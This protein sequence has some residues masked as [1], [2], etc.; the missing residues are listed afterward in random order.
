MSM[1]GMTPAY[2]GVTVTTPTEKPVSAEQLLMQMTK[3]DFMQEIGQ[4][5]YSIV[6][7][8]MDE[9]EKKEE[10]YDPLEGVFMPQASFLPPPPA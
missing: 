2:P 3:Q 1:D 9:A 6:S 5:V 7:T 4:M 8:C 10:A